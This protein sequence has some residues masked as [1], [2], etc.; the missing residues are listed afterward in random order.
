MRVRVPPIA[1]HLPNNHLILL[2]NFTLESVYMGCILD[3]SNSQSTIPH[4]VIRGRTCYFQMRVPKRHQQL[5]GQFIRAR[6][7]QLGGKGTNGGMQSAEVKTGSLPTWRARTL[8]DEQVLDIVL[9]TIY[10][11]TLS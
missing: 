9:T 1:P 8:V 4:T 11:H 10:S 3:T 5:Y 2:S 7:T 6:L